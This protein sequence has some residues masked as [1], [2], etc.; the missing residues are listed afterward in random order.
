MKKDSSIAY[1]CPLLRSPVL[2]FVFICLLGDLLQPALAQNTGIVDPAQ[3]RDWA[4]ESI[5]DAHQVHLCDTANGRVP[6]A[7]LEH[8]SQTTPATIPEFEVD[9]DASGR[10]ATS[11]PGG[12]TGTENAFFQNLGINGRTLFYLSSAAGWLD[13]QRGQRQCQV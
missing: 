1:L 7:S 10:I 11:Q 13:H 8:G 9:D 3:T 2:G 12:S 5:K 4:I 6:C